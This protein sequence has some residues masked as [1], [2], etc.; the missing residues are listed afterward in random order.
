MTDHDIYEKV[1]QYVKENLKDDEFKK[2]SDLQDFLWS[3]G[4]MVGK[5]GPEVLNIYLNEKSKL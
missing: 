4:K 3:I 1:E 5:S 2:L